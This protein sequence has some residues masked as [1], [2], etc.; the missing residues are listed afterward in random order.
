MEREARV[1]ESSDA[2]AQ[3]LALL[4]LSGPQ[5]QGRGYVYSRQLGPHGRP[6]CWVFP[7]APD[8]PDG[9]TVF[10]HADQVRASVNHQLLAGGYV[11]PLFYDTLFHDLR[12]PLTEAVKAARL[13]DRGLWQ[14][15]ASSSGITWTGAACLP[16]LPPLFPKIWR[17]LEHYT[18]DRAFREG[19]D[20]LDAF[21]EYLQ[22]RGDRVLVLPLSHF[23]GLDN[24]LEV[25]GNQLKLDFE[26][27]DLV[28]RS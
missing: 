15:D 2:T 6:I 16:T 23:T 22:I 9:G 17:R 10:V 25:Q 18:F 27:E 26:P 8:G 28:F 19:S 4:G 7:G 20:S 12:L 24:V 5:G 1:P 3:N 14:A 11:Y 13:E 21:P